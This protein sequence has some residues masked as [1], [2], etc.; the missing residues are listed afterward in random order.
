MKKALAALAILVALA[1]GFAVGTFVDL[2]DD[3]PG[4]SDQA[5][6]RERT[7]TT[8][9]ETRGSDDLTGPTGPCDHADTSGCAPGSELILT[10]DQWRCTQPL[11]QVAR[12]VGGTL[13]LKVTAKFTTFVETSG[14]V[15]DLR[16][17]C[18]GDGTDAID[19]ILD[20]QGDGRTKGGINDALSVK[21]DAHDIDITGNIDCGPRAEG[22][23]QDGIQAQG[24]RNI[25]FVDLEIGDWDDQRATCTGAEAGIGI[26][27]GGVADIIPT[28]HKCIRCRVIACRRGINIGASVGTE[29][30]DSRFRSGNPAER[31]EQLATGIVGLCSFA[32]ST[33][34]F[35]PTAREYVFD[36][37]NDPSVC[38]EYPYED[39][40]AAP[41]PSAQP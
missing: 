38:D 13:P 15:V 31:E 21:L 12:E 22:S 10:D 40:V 4:K 32:V 34:E 29:I 20:I 2:R 41:A 14:P 25:S 3:G 5:R 17:G 24:A 19:L 26:S 27:L 7:D 16:E 33:C 30:V 1:A 36:D 11:E 37:A 39:A 35:Q 18:E 28:G 8:N 6:E 23:H 9:A